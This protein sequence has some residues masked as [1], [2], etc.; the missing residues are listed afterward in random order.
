MTLI[1]KNDFV[2]LDFVAR[3]Q[4]SRQIFDLTNEG[5]AKKEG[6]YHQHIKYGPKVLCVGQQHIVKG[7][8]DAL[9]AKEDHASF[10]VSLSSGEAFGPKI[11]S[12]V[13][14]VSTSSLT[15]QNIRPY[16]GLQISA[17]PGMV[18]TIRSVTAGRTVVDFNHPLAGKSVL[19]EIQLHGIV[20]DVKEK[21]HSLVLAELGFAAKDYS[22]ER[23]E[24]ELALSFPQKIP[25]GIQKIFLERVSPLLPDFTI[26]FV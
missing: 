17:G 9:V 23:K 14:T 16:P 15:Q 7:V 5:L 20:D 1:K 21:I 22:L 19:Y 2:K 3:I 13:K 18:G 25:E 8:D 6:L 10:T 4:D 26:S 11:S 12:L 24:R